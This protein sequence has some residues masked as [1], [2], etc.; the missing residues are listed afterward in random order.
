MTLTPEQ[1]KAAWADYCKSR[2]T[3]DFSNCGPLQWFVPVEPA[4][5]RIPARRMGKTLGMERRLIATFKPEPIYRGGVF[6]GWRIVELN[7]T[8]VHE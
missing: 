4:M 8:V 7:G 2:Y 1:A 6:A 5:A 3:W